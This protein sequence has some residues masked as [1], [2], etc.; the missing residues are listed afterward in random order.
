MTVALASPSTSG[1]MQ[2]ILWGIPIA[3]AAMAF[4]PDPP[5]APTVPHWGLL[6]VAALIAALFQLAP[7]RLRYRLTP[8]GL[9]IN[10]LLGT[11]LL[12]YA[13][14]QAR[15]TAGSLGVRTFGTG[16]PGYLTG[17]FSFGSDGVRS[18]TALASVMSGG[19]LLGVPVNHE[20]PARPSF[21]LPSRPTSVAEPFQ[22]YFLTPADPQQFL[23]EL[24][25]R[26]AV[27]AQ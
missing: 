3:M 23:D 16:L 14:M 10:R 11:T 15:E 13:G 1:W 27:V 21:I 6:V 12:P 19:V 20:A 26:G 17:A 5:E 9:E 2:A 4:V 18:V 8:T 25:R 24:A 22:W 7:H